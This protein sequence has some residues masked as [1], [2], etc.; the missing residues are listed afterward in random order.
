MTA[1]SPLGGESREEVVTDLRA[2]AEDRSLDSKEAARR[3]ELLALWESH[4]STD[5]I[6]F[7]GI[8]ME[9]RR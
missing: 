4:R 7:V 5:P 3:R 8:H 2:L 6:E 9:R 1:V